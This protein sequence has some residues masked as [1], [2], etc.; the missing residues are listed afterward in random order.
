MRT[1]QK[2]SI[3]MYERNGNDV[4]SMLEFRLPKDSKIL[5][6]EAGF[7]DPMNDKYTP[8]FIIHFEGFADEQVS[9]ESH[10]LAIF[11]QGDTIPDA[12]LRFHGIGD[13]PFRKLFIYE[14]TRP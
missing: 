2:L 3:E 6:V 7:S 8:S 11:K 14:Y 9:F 13:H 5:L 12:P 4:K 1:I 10:K